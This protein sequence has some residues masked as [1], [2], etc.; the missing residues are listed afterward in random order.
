MEFREDCVLDAFGNAEEGITTY[1]ETKD[2]YYFGS[3]DL[4]R[5]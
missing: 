5:H 2:N 1:D 3:C 4:D